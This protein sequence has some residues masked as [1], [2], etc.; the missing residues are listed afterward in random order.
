[1]IATGA[2]V[3]RNALS[4]RLL[5]R[6]DLRL[7]KVF[8]IG[9]RVR[10]EGIAEAYNLFNHSNF[11]NYNGTVDS[12]TFGQPLQV[13]NFG[14]SGTAYVPRTLQLAARVTF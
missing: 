8:P 2:V 1:V 4:G 11:G 10:V 3:P 7:S 5:S 13:P 9:E 6:V 12:A 14:G